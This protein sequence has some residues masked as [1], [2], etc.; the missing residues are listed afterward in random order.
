MPALSFTTHTHPPSELSRPT[1]IDRL[2]LHW[3]LTL[4]RWADVRESR[5]EERRT[6]RGREH[7]RRALA[8][9]EA[10]RARADARALGAT[11]TV[12]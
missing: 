10:D 1:L 6:E 8:E 11:R 7:Y 9:A 4:V 12:R 2:A 5:L 3:G